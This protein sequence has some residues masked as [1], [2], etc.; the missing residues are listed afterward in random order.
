MWPNPIT[1]NPCGS[2]CANARP[3]ADGLGIFSEFEG[4]AAAETL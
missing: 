3:S 4:M 2:G 1:M